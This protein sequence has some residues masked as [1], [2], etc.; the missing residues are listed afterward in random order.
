MARL[1]VLN[2]GSS[3]VKLAVF[4]GRAANAEGPLERVGAGELRIIS[5]EPAGWLTLSGALV[6]GASPQ[7]EKLPFSPRRQPASSPSPGKTALPEMNG[8]A[9]PASSSAAAAVAALLEYL[10]RR[11]DLKSCDAAAHRIV[12]G[13]AKFEQPVLFSSSVRDALV[14]LQPLA[15]N[16]IPAELAALDEISARREGLPQV[17][18][19][20]TAFHGTL[21][22]VARRFPLPAPLAE[23]GIVRYGF[24]G[25]SYEWILH[26]LR[27]RGPLPGR[28]VAAHLGNGASLAAIRGGIS[29]DTTMGLTPLGGIPMGTRSGDLDPGVVIHLQRRCGYDLHDIE[30]LLDRESGL[31]GISGRTSDMQQLLAASQTDAASAL[32]VE[33]FCYG[34][35]KAIGAY[36]AALGGL[37]L[38][39]F[40]GGIGEHAA[41]VRARSLD[42]LE[43]LGIALDAAA[44]RRGIATSPAGGGV[45]SGNAAGTVISSP[46]SRV[47]VEIVAADEETMI[48][49]HA[50]KLLGARL[51][52]AQPTTPEV[53]HV[54]HP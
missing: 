25:L 29:V 16:H 48:A 24:H 41:E 2:C 49:R 43:F 17:L 6:Q 38:L 3:S 12:H 45:A 9:K 47:R 7:K 34:V 54:I 35:R 26:T 44:N 30:R 14:E 32:A 8:P 5:N 23:Q 27:G 20:D 18:C 39:A 21:P 19:F 40:T 31:I 22:P 42:G 36:A 50:E 33:M 10:D 15:P 52:P 51:R 11:G 28:I 46:S 4:A 37:D 13:G 53:S 1:L